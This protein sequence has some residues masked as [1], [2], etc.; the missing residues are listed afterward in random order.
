MQRWVRSQSGMTIVEVMIAAGLLGGLALAG[1]TLFQN[2]NKA[3][4]TVESNYE[5]ATTVGQIRSVLSDITNCT[6]SFTGKNI[7][8]GSVN[9][10]KKN[11]TS[12]FP[13]N[14][15]LPG[16]I[17]VKSYQLNNTVPNLAANETVLQITFARAKSALQMD[18][19]RSMKLVYTGSPTV[20]SCYALSN[21]SDSYW[22]LASNGTDIYY[23]G[24]SVGVGT[25][26]PTSKLEVTGDIRT[27]SGGD[28]ILGTAFSGTAPSLFSDNGELA[29]TTSGTQRMQIAAN[30]N[31]GLGTLSPADKLDVS[32]GA[33]FLTTVDHGVRVKADAGN[34]NAIYQ[35]TNNASSQWGAV[36]MNSTTMSFVIG[37]TTQAYIDSTGVNSPG[38]FYSSD[39]R[40]KKN[41][42]P[43]RDALGRLLNLEGKQFIWKDN[44]K[45]D[46]GFIAQQVEKVEPT[47]VKT[48]SKGFKSV[49]YGN[50]SAL[51]V[52]A[53]RELFSGQDHL[54]LEMDLL[55]E[56][57]RILKQR[58][59]LI[60]QKQSNSEVGK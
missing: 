21:T 28:F 24:G 12:V 19:V 7:N 10:I 31:V 13:I 56:E 8:G 37:A 11:G 30:G 18:V 9:V 35:F 46:I 39:K 44:G 14:T 22:Q 27:S 3:Q 34:I 51:I 59:L 17:Q 4:K 55:K 25:I 2:Q 45:K 47:L 36:S 48:D 58:L 26:A 38:F 29:F 16:D 33:T 50:I 42:S 23:I 57:N 43:L 60:E 41:I 5:V 54:K 49:A 40:L 53:I 6:A 15:N 52:E 1:M 20:V 32:G